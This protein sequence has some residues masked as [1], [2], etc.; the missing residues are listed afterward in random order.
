MIMLDTVDF[1]VVFWGAIK[2]G[3]IPVPINT[4][5]TPEQWRFIIQ[6]SRA[7]AVVLSPDLLPQARADPRRLSPASAIP[8]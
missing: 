2:A 1:P 8:T 4:L 5:M 6:D 7:D 3:V